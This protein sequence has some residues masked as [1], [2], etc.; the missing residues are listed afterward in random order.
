MDSQNLQQQINEV[1]AQLDEQATL[2]PSP[3]TDAPE[4]HDQ[5]H[6]RTF[7]DVYVIERSEEERTPTVEG[8][9]EPSTQGGQEPNA[10]ETTTTLSPQRGPRTSWLTFLLVALCT[11]IVG[12][13]SG[14][15]LLQL[16]TASAT[17]TIV[18]ASR[19]ITTTSTLHVVNGAADP[20][21]HQL[22]GRMLAPVTMSQAR[23]IPTTGTARQEAKAAHGLVTFYNAAPYVQTV[24]AGTSLTGADG[25]Q[26]ITDE[27]ATIPGA[28][29]PTEGQVTI[30]AHAVIAGAAG[31]I[32]AGDVYGQCCRLNTFVANR[33]FYGG[34]DARSYQTVTQQDV[35]GVATSLKTSLDRSVQAALQTQVQPTETLVTPPPCT[36]KITPDHQSGEEATQVNVIVD[37]TC[38]GTAYTT[39][40]LNALVTQIATADAVHQLGTGY[41]LSGTVGITITQATPKDHG[42]IDLQIKSAS[43][44]GYQLGD[45][46]QQ[47][48]K[49]MIAGMSKDK[50]TATLLRMTG[51][52][53]VSITLKSGTA[54]P[55]EQHIHLLFLETM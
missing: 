2:L 22:A 21:K 43:R 26:I 48:I 35:N 44:W 52:Q 32:K 7:I 51:V 45:V 19:Q 55:D 33:A 13:G 40:A 36:Q 47:A 38:T 41:A 28:I 20:T 30:P 46:Q 11:L 14:V 18:A 27:D 15:Y 6:P 50:A 53:S 12:T 3:T 49:A 25:V 1:L 23:T 54:L 24:N 4:T 9:L 31:D 37:R 42:S 8:T 16:L 17:V 39:Q 10:P 29:M 34:Q 5:Q